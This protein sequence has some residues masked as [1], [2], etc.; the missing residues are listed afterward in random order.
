[1]KVAVE[2]RLQL[3]NIACDE[4]IIPLWK[5]EEISQ[6]YPELDEAFGGTLS[7]LQQDKE[8]TGEAKEI[9][10]VH[11]MNQVAAKK[12]MIVGMGDPGK[13]DFVA[14][15]NA[16]GR[17]AKT[18]VGK[19]NGK[20]VVIDLP[21]TEHLSADRLAQAV[22]EA[23][24]LAEYNY[25]GYRQKP[26]RESDPVAAV[27]IL[28][29]DG[30]AALVQAGVAR[31]S[32]LVSGTNLARTLVN[33]P[34]NYLTPRALK[35][36]MVAVAERY[37]MT[38]E[39]LEKAKLEELGMGGVLSVAQGSE[40][41]P[42]VVAVKY[43]GR[44]TWDDVIGLVGKGVTFDTGGISIKPVAGME[45]MKSDM[46]GAATMIGALE[47]LGQIKPKVNVLAVVGTVENMPSGTAFR[48]GDVITTMSGKTVEIITTDA[49]GRLVLADCIT[50]AK[51]QGVS[52]LV[53]AATLTGGIV[54]ALGHFCSG[55]MTNDKAL[56][57]E[58]MKA[59]DV[60]GERLWQLPT[61][62]EYRSLNKSRFA[63]LKNSG[64][65]YGH[66][67]I[68]GVFLQEFVGETPW[69]HLDIA[70]TAYTASAGDMQP[71]GGTGAMTRT[72]VEFVSSRS[73]S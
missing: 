19:G 30:D 70:G 38:V 46:G 25:E 65:R 31:G 41:E 6:V 8:L 59:A 32:A 71:A 73:E 55:A 40:L 13:F 49:E 24:G 39:V 15:R 53:D 27:R 67:I 64:G 66:G 69:V 56:M 42:Y 9:T 48:P 7:G 29:A 22:T 68:G 20:T 51:K 11:G 26:K 72:I 58:L 43:Q 1:M 4:L 28:S 3:V 61:F 37:G 18:V 34:A 12:L 47:A 21:T 33:E 23:F 62:D 16:W 45:D 57:D 50:Y 36:A 10:V 17:A 54:V 2:K 52:C 35:D 60:A 14:A 44:D 63:D 5:G